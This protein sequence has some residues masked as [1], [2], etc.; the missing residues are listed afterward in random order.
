MDFWFSV[1]AFNIWSILNDYF[2][3]YKIVLTFLIADSIPKILGESKIFV[4]LI[5]H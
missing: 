5:L 3:T 4:Q 2:T 1:K